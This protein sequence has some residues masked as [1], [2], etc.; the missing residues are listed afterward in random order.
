MARPSAL[1]PPLC[2]L[3]F[4]KIMRPGDWVAPVALQARTAWDI[5]LHTLNSSFPANLFWAATLSVVIGLVMS[6]SMSQ[7]L[8]YALE[9]APRRVGMMAGL[10]FGFSFGMG[11]L[12]APGVVRGADGVARTP[13]D[14][15]RL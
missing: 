13:G 6:A 9:L 11:G 5:K 12:G 15:A 8:V 3:G 1:A 2:P 14:A 4:T 10:F 7:I